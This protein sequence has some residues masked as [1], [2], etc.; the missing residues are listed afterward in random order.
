MAIAEELA[1]GPIAP[2]DVREPGLKP[3]FGVKFIYG[4]G[5]MIESGYTTVAGFIFFYYTAVLGMSGSL[6]GLAL[7]IS[8]AVDAILD[9]FIG[10]LSDNVRSKFG[11]RLPLM[12]LGA[13]LMALSLG[14]LFAPP[15]GLAPFL[16]FGWLTL[17]KLSLRGFA[18]MF[19]LPYF[20]LGAEMADGYVERSQHR[21]LPHDRRHLRRRPDHRPGLFRV[22]RRPWRSAEAGELPGL[23][24]GDRRALLPGRGDLLPGR[25][26]LRG[27]PAATD[28]AP[29]AAGSG[30]ARAGWSRSSRTA[31]S[32]P[33][34]CRPCWPSRRPGSTRP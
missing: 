29:A 30:P 9:P 21:R 27:E 25:L 26:A 6:V 14:L 8:M 33:S 1:G 11:R 32:A 19:N 31:R 12:A 34:S 2:P 13:P 7:A 28:D 5:Q 10:S 17:S 24:L 20:A 4:F 22:F 18:S 16:L 23:R 3:S 15:A